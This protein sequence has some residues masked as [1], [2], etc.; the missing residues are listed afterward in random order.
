MLDNGEKQEPSLWEHTT[1]K[2]ERVPPLFCQVKALKVLQLS[3]RN[4]IVIAIMIFT[5]MED[6]QIL[7]ACRMEGAFSRVCFGFEGRKEIE[8]RLI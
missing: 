8:L 3:A 6:S 2:D 7:G 5:S 1:F 4:L